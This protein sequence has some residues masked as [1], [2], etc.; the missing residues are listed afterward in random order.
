MAILVNPGI[1]PEVLV[2][3]YLERYACTFWLRIIC[4]RLAS[5][6]GVSCRAPDGGVGGGW[7][8]R[9][10]KC[11]MEIAM[12]RAGAQRCWGVNVHIYAICT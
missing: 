10:N 9:R 1:I 5:V 3:A 11:S 4:G 2:K 8:R 7:R 6:I 12:I